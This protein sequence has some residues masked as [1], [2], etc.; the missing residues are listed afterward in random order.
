MLHQMKVGKPAS[1]LSGGLTVTDGKEV[2]LLH[3]ERF[4]V[5]SLGD[6]IGDGDF[7]IMVD[8]L[9]A[10]AMK[11]ENINEIVTADDLEAESRTATSAAAKGSGRIGIAIFLGIQVKIEGMRNRNRHEVSEGGERRENH[12]LSMY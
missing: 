8:S 11:K 1:I 4:S 5:L 6:K 3:P 7:H 2:G 10:F 9:G 12:S